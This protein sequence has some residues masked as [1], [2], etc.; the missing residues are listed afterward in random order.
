MSRRTPPGV[1]RLAIGPYLYPPLFKSVVE[2]LT[3]I[4]LSN[5]VSVLLLTFKFGRKSKR[6]FTVIKAPATTATLDK[7][8]GGAL[9]ALGDLVHTSANI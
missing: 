8:R 2:G 5:S 7:P 9:S 4:Q 1:C 3:Q 6:K